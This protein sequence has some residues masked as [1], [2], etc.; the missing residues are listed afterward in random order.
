MLPA[1][2]D[3]RSVLGADAISYSEI[4][5]LARCETAWRYSYGCG[6]REDHGPSASMALGS[7]LHRLWALWWSQV[8][9]W[10]E[11]EDETALWLMHRYAEKYVPLS[12]HQKMQSTEVPLAAKLPAGPWFFGFADGFLYD[13]DTKELWVAE[14]KT[15]AQLSNV[16]HL[17]QSLQPRLYVW[18]ARQMGHPVVGAM[19][20]VIRTFHPKTEERAARLA[21]DESF[22]RR[23]LRWSDAEL[24]PAVAEAMAAAAIRTQLQDRARVPLR[25][26]GPNCSWCQHQA[27]CFGLDVEVL[28]DEDF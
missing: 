17:A 12:L 8:S 22:E 27:P 23:W 9:G 4:S 6:E 1:D 13:T 3:P 11:T 14:L 15:T 5:T 28:D 20:D 10:Q 26:L 16:E 21:L 18:A 2:L 24:V 7:E 25:A 19:L